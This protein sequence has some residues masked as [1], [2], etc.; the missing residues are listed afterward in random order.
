MN[1]NDLK[2]YAWKRLGVRKHLAG[3]K[4]VDDLVEI[5]VQNWESEYLRRIDHPDNL[6]LF[7]Q[8]MLSN[9]KRV[10]QAGG[11][12]GNAEYGFIWVF[13]LSS[14]ASALIRILI[15]WWLKSGTNRVYMEVLKR[16]LN[17]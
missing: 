11:E 2:T 1:I 4:A 13:I 8:D 7:E 12:Y 9:M 17:Q 5:A 14:V 16:E 6:A 15:E 3:R 10:Y